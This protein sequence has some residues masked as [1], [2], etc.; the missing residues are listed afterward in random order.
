MTKACI[1]NDVRGQL[2]SLR[3]EAQGGLSSFRTE[4]FV[5]FPS[6]HTD[7]DTTHE[8]PAALFRWCHQYQCFVWVTADQLLHVG[9][10]FFHLT[11]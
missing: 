3:H 6:C 8:A 9:Y 11:Q 7:K 10:V 5:S 2:S 4:S 1:G